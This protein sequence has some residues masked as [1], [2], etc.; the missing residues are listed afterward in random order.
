MHAFDDELKKKLQDPAFA[1]AFG[2]EHGRIA[3]RD[4]IVNWVEEHRRKF[5]MDD[6]YFIYRDSFN[7]EDLMAFL[8]EETNED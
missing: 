7:S 4:R 8:F 1:L 6:A 3:E 2:I 5:E